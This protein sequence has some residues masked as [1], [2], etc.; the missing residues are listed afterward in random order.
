[1]ARS[2]TR[3]HPAVG[4]IALC[5]I[6][7]HALVGT[8]LPAMS[9]DTRGNL[10]CAEARDG[11]QT[12]AQTGQHEHGACCILACAASGLA[13]LAAACTV[14]EFPPPR[15]HRVALARALPTG[16]PSPLRLYFAARGPP[17]AT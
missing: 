2:S 6:V 11:E 4:V 14:V 12:P 5:A 7:L 3:R 16:I 9:Y 17:P 1:L 8:A 15:C 13:F 10:V